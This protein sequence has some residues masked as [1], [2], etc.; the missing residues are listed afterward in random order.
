[1]NHFVSPVR[2]NERTGVREE[3]GDHL[4][5]GFHSFFFCC[6]HPRLRFARPL[7]GEHLIF[8]K[9]N[10]ELRWYLDS[11]SFRI[12]VESTR[13]LGRHS[14]INITKFSIRCSKK[15]LT[16]TPQVPDSFDFSHLYACTRSW[17]FSFRVHV[18]FLPTT[19]TPSY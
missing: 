1:V 8:K 5:F 13:A 9:L 14:K 2:E 4:D 16:Q 17:V 11:L 15:G 12:F 19:F 3:H 6:I 10:Q 7:S 18:Y